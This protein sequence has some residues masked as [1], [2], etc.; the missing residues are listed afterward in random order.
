MTVPF[1]AKAHHCNKVNIFQPSGSSVLRCFVIYLGYNSRKGAKTPQTRQGSCPLLYHPRKGAK[2]SRGDTPW[3]NTT[4]NP[5]K[6]A[7]TN[8]TL[9]GMRGVG[10]HP[11]K[12]AVT[13]IAHDVPFHTLVQ[14]PQGGESSIIATSRADSIGTIPARGR[15]PVTSSV[16]FWCCCTIPVRG[17]KNHWRMVEFGT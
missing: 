3:I 11:R 9:Q 17:R 16:N 2:T 6:G 13:K 1:S 4:Y 14:S 7:I 12:G 8:Q 5:R 10:Y 15:K